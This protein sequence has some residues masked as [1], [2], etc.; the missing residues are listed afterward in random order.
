ML[1]DLDDV[2][3]PRAA[4]TGK[5]V[6]EGTLFIAEDDDEDEYDVRAPV[7]VYFGSMNTILRRS[8]TTVPQPSVQ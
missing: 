1:M 3:Q 5:R 6:S 4:S 2:E 7:N 8:N